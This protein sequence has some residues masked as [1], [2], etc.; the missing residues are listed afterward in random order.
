MWY[1]KHTELPKYIRDLF[2]PALEISPEWHLK[3][4]VAV[5]KHVCNAVS[6]TINLPYEATL[7]DV[8]N[9]DYTAWSKGAKGVTIYR[10][11]SRENQV[12]ENLDMS[13]LSDKDK[14][15]LGVCPNCG[16]VDFILHQSGCTE[17]AS[18]AWSLCSL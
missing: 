2:K 9:I 12:L 17:C 1:S 11:N 8:N 4:L 13:R 15:N 18:C 5:Q 14:L 7:E 3:H 6:K 10:N 16:A